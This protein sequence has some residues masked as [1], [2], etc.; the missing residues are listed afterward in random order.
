MMYEYS[1]CVMTFG[2]KMGIKL[3]RFLSG[4]E[5]ENELFSK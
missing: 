1:P 3:E 4:S 5:Y 2:I